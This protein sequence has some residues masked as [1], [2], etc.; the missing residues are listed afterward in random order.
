ME[1]DDKEDE[2][3]RNERHRVQ[4]GFTQND[5]V[6]VRDLSKVTSAIL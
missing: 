1:D 6:V 3:V 2:E 5:A 4:S